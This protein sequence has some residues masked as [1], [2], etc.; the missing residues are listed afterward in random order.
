MRWDRDGARHMA[1]RLGLAFVLGWFGVQELRSPSEW[2]V[3]V[4]SFVGNISPLAVNDLVLIHGFFLLL[5]CCSITAGLLYL[6]G[7]LL[8]MGLLA[9]ILFG[10][11]W[12]GGGISDLVIRDVGLFALAGAL[13]ID[14]SRFWHL[15]NAL[16]E[17]V[18]EEARPRPHRT[19]RD[20]VGSVAAAWVSRVLAAT[21]LTAGV[22]G[23]GVVLYE[24]GSG[25]TVPDG[26]ALTLAAAPSASS[27]PSAQVS[28]P[29]APPASSARASAPTATPASSSVQFS[30]WQFAQYSFQIYP[31]PASSDALNALAGFSLS[32]QDQGNSVVVNL[33]ALS[34]RYHDAQ[35]T[36]TK[37][38]TAYFV[39]TSMRDDPTNQENNLNDDGIVVVNPQ[40]YL[41]Q[42]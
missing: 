13:A 6:P 39:E 19:L 34:S 24:T 26:S 8:A 32:V 41:L 3:F 21:A 20:V 4:P 35:Y 42:S 40:G 10:L 12:D 2:A 33:K 17:P 25:A 23:A 14:P 18:D 38:D 28:A 30:S 11:W 1:M 37:G 5:A 22:L 27:T 15:D 9:E 29:N 31:G 7:C 16:T 36:V